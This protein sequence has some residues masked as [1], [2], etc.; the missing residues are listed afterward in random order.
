LIA[1]GA[2]F[3]PRLVREGGEAIGREA[4]IRGFNWL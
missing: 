3:N 1:L 4:R 2:S